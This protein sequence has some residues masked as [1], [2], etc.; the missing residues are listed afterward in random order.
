ME[1][2]THKSFLLLHTWNDQLQSF[3]RI[4]ACYKIYCFWINDYNK[5]IKFQ[6]H[7][8]CTIL[9]LLDSRTSLI[10][11]PLAL[12]QGLLFVKNEN[13]WNQQQPELAVCG[14]FKCSWVTD[15]L[16]SKQELSCMSKRTNTAASLTEHRACL[17][18]QPHLFLWKSSTANFLYTGFK[19]YQQYIG[20]YGQTTGHIHRYFKSRFE[21]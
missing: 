1:Q 17:D 15:V 18:L 12:N 13:S 19:P 6:I 5:N 14:S 2:T 7:V 21:T 10:F 11:C 9:V 8:Y 20:M 3:N 16:V 4:P